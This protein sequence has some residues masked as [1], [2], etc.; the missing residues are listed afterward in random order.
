MSTRQHGTAVPPLPSTVAQAGL[1]FYMELRLGKARNL[2]MQTDMSVINVAL[3]CGFA[4]PSHFLEC[5]RAH[6][7][8]T[9]Y[10]RAR[11][12]RDARKGPEGSRLGHARLAP[13]ATAGRVWPASPSRRTIFIG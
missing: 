10:T 9:P 13:A 8:T 6:Y 3:A 1:N 12:A 4:S 5:Y 11:I 2:L 7:D